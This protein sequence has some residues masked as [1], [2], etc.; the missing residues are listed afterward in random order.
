MLDSNEIDFSKEAIR[1]ELNGMVQSK[2]LRPS[3]NRARFLQLGIEQTIGGKPEDLK[4]HLLGIEIDDC[5]PPADL[6]LDS[7]GRT[8]AL[9][10]HTELQA[11]WKPRLTSAPRANTGTRRGR[12]SGKMHGCTV[13]N[14]YAVCD[15]RS[16]NGMRQTL[17]SK[18]GSA[19]KMFSA[20]VKIISVKFSTAFPRSCAR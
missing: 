9:P 5:R 14:H 11:Y 7:I 19:T 15:Q 2:F 13:R 10:P 20:Q 18:T 6:R 8:E 1:A 17:T 16:S 12:R 3:E 4:E